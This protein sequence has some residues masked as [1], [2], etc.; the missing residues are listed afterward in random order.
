MAGLQGCEP[1]FF[2][3]A[4]ANLNCSA[5]WLDKSY[6]LAHK[7][8]NPFALEGSHPHLQCAP[9]SAVAGLQGCEPFFFLGAD[10]NLNCSADW[11]DKSYGLAHKRRN[12]FAPEGSHPHLRCAPRSA[13]TG[14]SCS[15]VQ[16]RISDS[17]GDPHAFGTPVA[18]SVRT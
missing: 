5:D 14:L 1:F 7:R 16:M 11:L 3:G 10:A 17:L 12:P 15:W 8:R 9:R 4:D 6:G 18:Q 13:V 2:L